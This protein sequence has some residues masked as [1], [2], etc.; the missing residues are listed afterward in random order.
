MAGDVYYQIDDKPLIAY[1]WIYNALKPEERDA[2]ASGIL[3]SANFRMSA[4]D[5]WS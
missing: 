4:M 3:A 5:R 1:D 2:I